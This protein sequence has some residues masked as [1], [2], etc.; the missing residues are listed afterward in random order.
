MT[1]AEKTT[2]WVGAFRYYLGRTRE[3]GSHPLGEKLT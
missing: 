1:D 2:L 3:E